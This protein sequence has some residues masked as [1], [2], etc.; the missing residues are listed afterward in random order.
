MGL[1]EYMSRN[2]VGL[3][4]HPSGHDEDFLVALINLLNHSLDNLILNNVANQKQ[5]PYQLIKN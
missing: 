2:P 1:I 3:A 4:I 5:A